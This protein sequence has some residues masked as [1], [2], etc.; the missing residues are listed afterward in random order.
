[1]A[2]HTQN[3]IIKYFDT[4]VHD[5]T[6]YDGK[7]F[8]CYCSKDFSTEE[9]NPHIQDCIKINGNQRIKMYQ[10]TMGREI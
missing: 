4:I 10:K 5:H 1:M 7:H 9:I 6:L 3:V 2:K 8:C